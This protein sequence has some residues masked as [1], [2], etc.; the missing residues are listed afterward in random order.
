M[1]TSWKAAVLLSVAAFSSSFNHECR[2][3]VV[4]DSQGFE[5]P[6]YAA[7]DLAGQATNG[8]QPWVHLFFPG[9]GGSTAVVQSGVVKSGSQAVQLDKAAGD[10]SRWAVDLSS[11]QIPSSPDRLVIV[12]WDMRIKDIAPT[13]GL[14]PFLGVEV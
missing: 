4:L 7:G 8:G 5:A 6:S 9:L 3:A 13:S 2:G 12:Q 10:D 11:G 14:G 1:P